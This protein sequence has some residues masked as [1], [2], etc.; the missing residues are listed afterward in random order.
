[1]KSTAPSHPTAPHST[2][3]RTAHP[4]GYFCWC[5]L[6]KLARH[7]PTV[8]FGLGFPTL[9]YLIF[10]SA[11]PTGAANTLASMA[12]YGALVVSLQTFSVSLASERFL[13]WNKLLRTTAMSTPLYLGAKFVVILSTGVLSLLLLFVVASLTGTV[14]LGLATWTQL[15][16]LMVM[17]MVPLAF[18]GL[19]LGLLGSENLT[20]ALSTGL[21][22]LLSFASGLF[23]PLQF[24]PDLIKQVAPYLPSYHLGQLGWITVNSFSHDRQPLWAHILILC[25]YTVVFAALAAWAYVRDENTTFG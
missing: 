1:M 13:G 8:L 6:L 4:W 18:L 16:L 20:A 7:P 25:G 22:L 14:Q 3:S 12:A 21:L 10:G 2:R 17:G 9:F 5:E 11:F 15:L 19:F 23:I 24:A